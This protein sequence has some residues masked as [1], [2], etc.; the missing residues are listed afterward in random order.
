M[1]LVRVRKVRD[2]LKLCSEVDFSAL[3]PNFAA[4]SN[5]KVKDG[6]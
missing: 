5:L 3:D 2:E 6:S 1:D 4:F